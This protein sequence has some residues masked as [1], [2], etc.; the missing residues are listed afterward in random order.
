MIEPPIT[1]DQ[2]REVTWAWWLLLLLGLLSVVAGAIVISKP[3]DSLATLAVIC[4][5]FILLDSIF[6]LAIAVFSEHGGVAA[7]LGVVGIVIGIILVRHPTHSVLAI[8]LLIGIW[9]IAIGVIR[10]VRTFALIEHRVWNV[11]VGVIEI[12]A[13]IV[14]VSSPNIGYATLAVLVGI[15][16]ILNGIALL[17]LGWSMFRVRRDP[18]LAEGA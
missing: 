14:I 3:S 13:G 5:I 4:G 10:L 17:A 1:R 2:I 16:F 9:L 15:G 12:I 8:A 11:V 6:E 18:T 7:L